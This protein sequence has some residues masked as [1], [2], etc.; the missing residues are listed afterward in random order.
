[1]LLKLTGRTM[2]WSF[3]YLLAGRKW[4]P[5]LN[6]TNT[7]VHHQPWHTEKSYSNELLCLPNYDKCWRGQ[8]PTEV[9]AAF[10]SLHC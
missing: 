2:L 9:Q 5:L 3:S 1:V 7:S 10:P 4:L 8:P 6:T